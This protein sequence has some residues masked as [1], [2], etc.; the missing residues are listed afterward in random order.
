MKV[1]KN[2]AFAAFFTLGAFSLATYTACTKD[3]KDPCLNVKCLNGGTCASGLCN[4]ATGYEGD[5]CSIVSRTKFLGNWTAKDSFNNTATGTYTAAIS[6]ATEIT[7]V[8]I[9]NFSKGFF[10]ADVKATISGNTLTIQRQQPDNDTFFVTGSGTYNPGAN[11]ISIQ[12]E[13]EN[14]AGV[15]QTYS[16]T[17]SK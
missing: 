1:L 11:T 16:G 17:W 10:L 14:P 7:G 8:F 3:E 4:C 6:A 12:Y 15:V 5:S 2:I 9:G 13:L